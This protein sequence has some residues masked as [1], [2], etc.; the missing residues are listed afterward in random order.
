M[1]NWICMQTSTQL[2]GDIEVMFFFL[3]YCTGYCKIFHE[4]F[5]LGLSLVNYCTLF[6]IIIIFFNF[7]VLNISYISWLLLR[8]FSHTIY[9]LKIYST[10]NN[11]FKFLIKVT[12]LQILTLFYQSQKI[13][14][15]IIILEQCVIRRK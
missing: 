13:C 8:I 9:N 5:F 14:N 6:C 10:S 4:I 12:F 11:I 15:F 2:I 7:D 1:A 3:T